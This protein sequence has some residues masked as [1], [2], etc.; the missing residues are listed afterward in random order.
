MRTARP[1][2]GVSPT[3]VS[4]PKPPDVSLSTKSEERIERM[5]RI[6]IVGGGVGGL[7]IACRIA[8]RHPR[9]QVVLLEKNPAVGG[10]MG[11]F[12]VQVEGVGTFRHERGPSLLLLPHIYH[13][14]FDDLQQGSAEQY[15]ITMKRCSPAYQVVFDDGDRINV[16]FDRS[17]PRLIELEKE[18]RRTMDTFETNGSTK[19]DEYMDICEA[20]LDCGL[21]NFIEERLDLPSFRKFLSAALGDLGKAWPLKPHSDVLDAI[22]SSEKMKALASFQ[23]L[24]VG[25]EPFANKDLPLGGVID[26]TAPAV[27]GLLS[28]IELHPTSNK[29]GVFAPLGGFRAVT[30][31]ME[32]LAQDLGVLVKT[33]TTVTKVTSEGVYCCETSN[34]SKKW[35]EAADYTVVNADLP[36]AKKTLLKDNQQVD[37]GP[38]YDW[39][40][41]YRFS[42][43]VIAFHWSFTKTL[44]DL[45]T[46]NVFMSV[47]SRNAAEKSWEVIRGNNEKRL[48]EWDM[49][50]PFNFYVHRA[51]LTDPSTAPKV[52][53]SALYV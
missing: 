39:D 32:S 48:F 43:G 26:T 38:K 6:I 22:F 52:N 21:P 36:Y 5:P 28:A 44:D 13:A 18:S 53:A 40:E 16:G 24:Y 10:R 27:F 33:E 42:C 35:F 3:R 23:D 50:A 2:S 12:D 1:F 9:S 47:K 49:N 4:K 8:F 34:T 19:W 37:E 29:C 17:D 31:G 11:S 15:G 41:S 14:L 30:N 51:S 7:A 46:H 25:L 45:N 20:F